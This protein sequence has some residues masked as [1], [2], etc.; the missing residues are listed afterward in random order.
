MHFFFVVLGVFVLDQLVKN[1]VVTHMM[2]NESLPVIPGVF[3]L[4]Y[5]RNAG[6]AFGLLQH[7][8]W[9]F[10]VV[11]AVLAAATVYFLPRLSDY[12]SLFHWGLAL[13][14]GGAA[15]NAWDRLQSGVVIDFLDCRI[16]PVFNIA[17]MAI[18]VGVAGVLYGLCRSGNRE[19]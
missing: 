3:H 16:W 8:T 10:L 5:I 14:V 15:G 13:L 2:L 11:A 7:H 18:V 9:F 4:T 19:E 12:G 1:Y 6:A 17:D